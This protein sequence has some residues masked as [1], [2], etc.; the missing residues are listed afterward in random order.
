MVAAFLPV[1][2]QHFTKRA[3]G[4]FESLTPLLRVIE[5][6]TPPLLDLSVVGIGEK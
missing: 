6:F 5:S 1:E 2:K 4:L 3:V